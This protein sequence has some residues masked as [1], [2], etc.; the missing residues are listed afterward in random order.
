MIQL[1]EITALLNLGAAGR[2]AP[3]QTGGEMPNAHDVIGLIVALLIIIALGG[4]L[5]RP[6]RPSASSVLGNIRSK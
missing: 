4:V 6:K 2:F 1:T 3:H 5:K